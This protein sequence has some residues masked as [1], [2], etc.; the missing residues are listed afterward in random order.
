M[1]VDDPGSDIAAAAPAIRKMETLLTMLID[2][3]YPA[4]ETYVHLAP[5]GKYFKRRWLPCG[6]GC[7]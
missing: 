5:R 4:P 1:T 7:I 3:G 2:S 6:I